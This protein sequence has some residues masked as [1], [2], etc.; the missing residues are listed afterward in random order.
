M[1][2]VETNTLFK[3]RHCGIYVFHFISKN[4]LILTFSNKYDRK[5]SHVF[6]DYFS[7]SHSLD[8]STPL[9]K[10][11]IYIYLYINQST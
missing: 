5:K 6:K 11:K 3:K 8:W 1:A 7:L 9:R 2:N 4:R 10:T